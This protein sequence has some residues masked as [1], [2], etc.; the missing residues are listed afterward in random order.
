ML[1]TCW[2]RVPPHNWY[3]LINI[4]NFSILVH[5]VKTVF[6]FLTLNCTSWMSGNK[7]IWTFVY[8]SLYWMESRIKGM[9][10]W[11]HSLLLMFSYN[12][13][14]SMQLCIPLHKHILSHERF[15]ENQRHIHKCREKLLRKIKTQV[16]LKQKTMK[17]ILKYCQLIIPTLFLASGYML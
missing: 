1:M 11:I 5:F 14:H 2:S 15:P 9:N 8:W 7:S 17:I 6:F 16:C 10:N 13:M 12:I 3:F 4:I